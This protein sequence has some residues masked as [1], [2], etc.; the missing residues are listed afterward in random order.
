MAMRGHATIQGSTDIPTLYDLLPGYLP[1]P[2]A[3][4]GDLD[5][6]RLRRGTGGQTS[7][8]WSHFDKYIV[9]LL[10]AW[11]GEAA[12]TENDFG[13]G[14]PAEDLTGN[15]SHF[16]TT[17]RA[18]DGG[19]DGMF[20]IGQN[21]AVG[22][23]HAGLQR[24]A[25]AKLKWLVV[26]DLADLETASFWKDSPEIRAGEVRTEDI[27]TEVFLMPAAGH[28]EK[29]GHFTNTQRLLQWH[30][31]ALDP[32][33]DARSELDFMHDLGKRI[34][35][36]YAASERARDWPIRNLTWDYP[37]HGDAEPRRAAGDQRLR[38][39]DG[40]SCVTGFGELKS[41]GTTAS[42]LLD[43]LGLLRRQRQPGPAAQPRRPRRARRLGLARVGLGVAG[44]PPHP[45][46]PR[47][48]RPR[49]QAVVGAQEA[50]LV[51]R[52]AGSLGRLRRAGLPARQAPRLPARG[53]RE[54]HGRDSRRR[55]VHHDAG[56]PRLAVLAQRAAGRRRSRRTTNRSSRRCRT[57]STRRCGANPLG[58]TW[59]RPENPLIEQADDRYPIV[60]S[61]FRLTEH[62]TAGPMSRNL[63]WLAE[64]QPE[65]FA[66][67]DPVLAR[68]ARDQGR[69]VDGD[70]DAAGRDRGAREG[71]QPHPAAADGRAH[72]PPDLPAVALGDVH[73]Q[74]SRA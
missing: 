20:V 72:H 10:K 61:T 13:F 28:V 54:G 69:G 52:G 45:L 33:G 16:V 30:D 24:R 67:I 8:W 34:K 39:E 9:S 11:Y 37:V 58:I 31:K 62:H 46:Q 49:G 26:R 18:L 23:Q 48:R 65:M 56:R 40:R 6:R 14:R 2:R 3:A 25:L 1:M 47:V 44:Q 53:R 22:S 41:D 71:D 64:L 70:R 60:A 55:P 36:H 19:L 57:S 73:D 5:A 68:E 74:P 51:G 17:M 27:K 29:E 32:P 38:P 4:E 7:G 59:V 15:H 63:P 12:T 21:P 35:A 43:L 42:R 66:E 50:N